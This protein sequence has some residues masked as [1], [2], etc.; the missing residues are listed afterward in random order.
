MTNRIALV[1]LLVA[2]GCACSKQDNP[3][4][5]AEPSNNSIGEAL[6]KVS[7]KTITLNS[8][9][10]AYR[11]AASIQYLA[12][13]FRAW[14][15]NYSQNQIQLALVKD[16]G[17]NATPNQVLQRAYKLLDLGIGSG[18]KEQRLARSMMPVIASLNTDA[19]SILAKSLGFKSEFP[20]E[21]LQNP[22]G[23]LTGLEQYL[24]GEPLGRRVLPA[25]PPVAPICRRNSRQFCRNC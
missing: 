25:R 6:A 2:F 11:T 7:N 1:L 18:G 8:W 19:G 12:A 5:P 16:F 15:P 24:A 21:V 20:K 3:P 4:A 10:A 17:T 22:K 9:D 14:N 13:A 23:T